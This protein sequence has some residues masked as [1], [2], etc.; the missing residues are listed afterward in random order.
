MELL[1]PDNARNDAR[2]RIQYLQ[3]LDVEFMKEIDRRAIVVSLYNMFDTGDIEGLDDV[4]SP[5]L[6]DH[7]PILGASSPLEGMRMLVAAIRD[8][9][10]GTRHELI[11]QD[12]TEDGWS[13]SQWRMTAI[14]S[15]HWFG[16]PATGRPVS[17][18][19]IDLMRIVDNK[20]KEMRHVEELFQLQ[21]QIS[22]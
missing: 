2:R 20:I 18:T 10:T 15:G 14:H 16:T 7:N 22:D 12:E 11:Y 3:S 13:V 5:D 4:L 19:G 8:G 21:G 17:F 6:V 9:F 1:S